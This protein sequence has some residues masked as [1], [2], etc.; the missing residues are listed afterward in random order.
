MFDAFTFGPNKN[1]MN[2]LYIILKFKTMILLHKLYI[3]KEPERRM[4]VVKLKSKFRKT[5]HYQITFTLE[6]QTRFFSIHKRTTESSRH[7][8][9]IKREPET[10]EEVRTKSLVSV[11]TSSET[12]EFFALGWSVDF[13]RRLRNLAFLTLYG[14]VIL[15]QMLQ[16]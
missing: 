15:L 6:Q 12:T 16:V 8:G 5:L 2:T 13:L 14:W 7:C 4:N 10:L 11:E 9:A 1:N 3:Q